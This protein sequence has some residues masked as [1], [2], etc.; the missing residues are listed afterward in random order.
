MSY[1][2]NGVDAIRPAPARLPRE[3]DSERI[4]FHA[5]N[6]ADVHVLAPLQAEFAARLPNCQ[7]VFSAE[8]KRGFSQARK[9]IPD[10][11]PIY[12]PIGFN[13]TVQ[14]AIERIGPKLLVLADH[15]LCSSL[16]QF[17]QAAGVKVA[18]VN[19]RL[20][21][22]GY[23]GYRSLRWLA[24][25]TLRQIDLIATQTEEN[26]AR[27]LALGARPDAARVTGALEFG[28]VEVV[29]RNLAHGRL[30]AASSPAVER[31]LDH[32]TSLLGVESPRGAT[33]SAA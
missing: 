12:F 1:L 31:T 30:A 20:S 9:H 25:P 13:W 7:C 16:I 28:R 10:L 22:M 19:A 21:D 4:W 23:W 33:R 14:R 15:N 5:V 26:A 24:A 17:S 11:T 18:V 3:S 32:L 8:T 6:A 2:L 29:R 27:F